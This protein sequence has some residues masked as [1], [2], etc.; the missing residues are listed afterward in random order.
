MRGPSPLKMH[1]DLV[2]NTEASQLGVIPSARTQH[3]DPLQA[4]KAFG[5]MPTNR[6]SSVRHGLE[7]TFLLASK[8]KG[9]F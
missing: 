6:Q 9:T 2:I 4:F 8:A 5:Y 7:V 1:L 3:I